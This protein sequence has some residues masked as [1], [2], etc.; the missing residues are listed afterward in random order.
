MAAHDGKAV[1]DTPVRTC[2]CSFS[3][4]SVLMVEIIKYVPAGDVVG[5]KICVVTSSPVNKS[6]ALKDGLLKVRVC[7][8]LPSVIVIPIAEAVAPVVAVADGTVTVVVA[9]AVCNVP[10]ELDALRVDDA[11]CIKNS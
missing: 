10:K 1:K 6:P 2:F 8:L 11:C 9:L 7:A 3:P 4:S 5:G